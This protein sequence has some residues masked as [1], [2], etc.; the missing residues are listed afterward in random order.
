MADYDVIVVGSGAG[1]VAAGLVVARSGHSLLVLEA[2][3][4]FGGCMSPMQKAG[5]SFDMGVHYLGQLAE[6]DR[7]WVALEEIGLA[8]R[9]QFVELDPD[10]IDR[11]VFPDFELRLCR[12]RERFHEQLIRLFPKEERGINKYFQVYERVTRASESF[13][14]LESGRWNLARWLAANPVMLKYG[15]VPYQ[16]LLDEVTSDMRLQTA[17][18]APWFDYMLPPRR[19]SVSYGV[20]TWHHY[21]SG[22]FYPRGGSGALRNAF[23][24]ALAEQGAELRCGCRIAAIDR[25]GAAFVVTTADGERWTARAV[26]SDVDPSLTLGVLM[27]PANVP[28]R[29]LRKARQLRPSA[30]LFGVC[31]G[32]DLDLPALGMTNGNLVPYRRYDVNKIFDATMAS[33]SP[34]LA[35]CF[36]VNSPSVRNPEGGLAPAGCHSLQILAGA[37]YAAFERWAALSATERGGD[38]ESQVKALADALISALESHVPGLS[39]RIRFVECVTPLTLE[40]GI[41]L[42][43]GGI[44]GAELTPDQSGPGRFPDGT[45]GV[46]GL[47]LAGAGVKGSSVYYCVKSGIQ[48][49]RRAVSFLK[50][51]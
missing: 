26:V 43:R 20:G 35:S 3:P 27:N 28:S 38:Y 36:L 21:L 47:F 46:K 34:E 51:R 17:L 7:F 14:D 1:G 4:A 25:M 5:Y 2:A 30:S 44:Y 42:V 16:T 6:G 50:V 32:T 37:S 11:Y 8:G 40:Q 18:A 15:R 31:I 39:Q 41:N 13:L 10:A 29:I 19:A 45:G 24:D 33:E 23:V 49:G 12:G 9:V 48:A 22:G